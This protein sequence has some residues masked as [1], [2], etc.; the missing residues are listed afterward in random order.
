M[1]TSAMDYKAKMVQGL[2]SFDH[3]EHPCGAFIQR[4]LG[5]P[6]YWVL[7]DTKGARHTFNTMQQVVEYLSNNEV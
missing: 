5:L 7:Q 2:Y 1:K 4:Y 3:Y 6:T